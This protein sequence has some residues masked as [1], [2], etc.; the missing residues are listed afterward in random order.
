[1]KHESERM[2]GMIQCLECFYFIPHPS[3]FIL[4][5]SRLRVVPAT[6]RMNLFDNPVFPLG[7]RTFA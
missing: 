3:S 1:M 6:R 4:P 2:K 7:L 5:L